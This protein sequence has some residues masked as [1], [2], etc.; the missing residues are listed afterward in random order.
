MP[1]RAR[2][3]ACACVAAPHHPDRR[4]RRLERRAFRFGGHRAAHDAFRNVRRAARSDRGRRRA[5]CPACPVSSPRRLRGSARGAGRPPRRDES[6]G[7]R[8]PRRMPD[9]P[10]FPR[11]SGHSADA[12][13][14]SN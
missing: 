4:A 3:A 11:S 12:E 8:W 2:A 9:R 5:G 10:R 7:P 6:R 14:G 1:K 13:K